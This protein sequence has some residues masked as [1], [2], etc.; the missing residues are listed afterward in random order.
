MF[1]IQPVTSDIDY[2]RHWD[3]QLLACWWYA[4]DTV[5]TISRKENTAGSEEHTASQPHS[6][7]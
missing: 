4:G 5:D 3:L 6:H 2:R 7:V 1:M